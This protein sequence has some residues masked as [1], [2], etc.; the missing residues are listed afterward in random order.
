M[1]V[2]DDRLASMI[3]EYCRWRLS[4]DPVVLD[5]PGQKPVLDDALRGLIRATPQDPEAVFG[6]YRDTLAPAVISC[7]SPRFLAFIPA[8]PTKASLLFDMVVSASSLQGS[9]WLEAAGAVAAENQTLRVLADLAGL[10]PSAGGCFVSGGSARQPL[11]PDRGPR[12]RAPAAR[13]GGPA[14]RRGELPGPL[15]DRQGAAGASGVDAAGRP[16]RR[17]SPDRA[18]ARCR[19]R[20]RPATRQRHRGRRD[21]RHH[22]RRHRRR[23]GRDRRGGRGPRLW[24]HVD[25]AYGGGRPV[26]AV[27]RPRFAGIERADSLVVDPHKWLFAPFDCA[28]L[29]TATRSWPGPST[30]R[31][32]YLDVTHTDAP[33]GVEPERLRVPPDPPGPRAWPLWFSLAV[34]G[35]DAYARAVENALRVAWDAATLI[36]S[37]DHLE[38]IRQPEL[39]IVLFRRREWGPR[40][41]IRGRSGFSPTRSAS[42]PRRNGRGKP[43]LVLRSSTRTP[44]SRLSR[45][46]WRPWRSFPTTTGVL[47]GLWAPKCGSGKNRPQKKLNRL[48]KR[49]IWLPY[50]AVSP[51]FAGRG[52]SNA[53]IRSLHAK[54]AQ[55]GRVVKDRKSWLLA[56][57]AAAGVCAG[58]LLIS[59]PPASA[60][61]TETVIVTATGPLSALNAVLDVGGSVL[62]SF[63]VING[64]EATI[65]PMEQPLLAALP[66]IVV[67]PDLSVSLQGDTDP[68]DPPH[69]P[70]EVFLQETGASDSPRRATPAR[71]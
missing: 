20:R 41:T 57:V 7:D 21:R 15:L 45:R 70:A 37:K 13:S 4:L 32:P 67:T 66:G 44:R 64:V 18:R 47:G 55:V 14:R 31:T 26:R 62:N 33:D 36:A 71:A 65:P 28:A 23:P 24:L 2:P 12:D 68:G 8:A 16:V 25:G 29:S 6:I 50:V 54:P 30:P 5:F 59:V 61:L 53:A 43:S 46:S 63:Q 40:T 56:S 3:F 42:S 48:A 17:L 19:A 52:P 9:S 1:F 11:G 58:G 49:A 34:H 35:T 27:C 60:S 51:R 69:T 10:P 38:L 22:E 39:S